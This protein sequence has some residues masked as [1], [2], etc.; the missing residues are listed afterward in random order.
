MET[1]NRDLAL[2]NTAFPLN[3]ADP[4]AVRLKWPWDGRYT[5]MVVLSLF[6]FATGFFFNPPQELIRGMKNILISPSGL[7][8]D[9]FVVGN[10]GASMLNSG[11]VT[12][13]GILL[14]RMHKMEMDGAL[15]AALFTLAGFSF[16]GKNLYNTW[17]TIVGVALYAKWRKEPFR[18]YLI[19]ALFST[20]LGPLISSVT[21]GIG[22]E[23]WTGMIAGNLAGIIAGFL[24]PPLTAH[25]MNFHKGFNIYNTG[26]SAGIIGMCFMALFRGLGIEFHTSVRVVTQADRPL[27]LW[28]T[29]LF[30]ILFLSGMLYSRFTSE[31]FGNVLKEEGRL[32]TDFVRKHGFAPV[33][34]NMGLL[35][36]LS[37]AYVYLV[38][39]HLNGPA[40][41]GIF[42]VVGFGAYGKHIRNVLPILLGVYI[43]STWNV[44][45]VGST[46]A[47]LAALFGT[48]LAPMAGR[49]GFGIGIVA[50]FLHMSM[51]M[52]VS[53]LH[54]GLNLYNN[55]FSGG[56]VAAVMVPVIE[57]L[58]PSQKKES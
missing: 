30:A 48:T 3:H 1:G 45:E 32:P 15:L 51:T 5:T 42:T 22:L 33:L 25:F 38:G 47:V 53:Y 13:T 10:I 36:I 37:T 19:I 44:Y 16:F 6:L 46:A 21:F 28:L 50:G 24:L 23:L 27:I 20:A 31:T 26:F 58:F 41:G 57:H 18:K 4:S 35:G 52:N 56:F 9:Y 40:L 34:F 14:A 54:G 7:I 12:L 8:T 49:Y 11:L 2:D 17:G 43:A 39:G 55:G 29:C